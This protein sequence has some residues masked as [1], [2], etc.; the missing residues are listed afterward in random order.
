[1]GDELGTGEAAPPV[2]GPPALYPLCELL[3]ALWPAAGP[4]AVL[5][6][7]LDGDGQTLA[8]EHAALEMSRGSYA[9]LGKRS[10]EGKFTICVLP[11]QQVVHLSI[12]NLTQLPADIFNPPDGRPA[13]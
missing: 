10:D 7:K 9:V 8:F 6:I 11:W 5:E 3:C 13:T 1:V 12:R 4:G 2:S